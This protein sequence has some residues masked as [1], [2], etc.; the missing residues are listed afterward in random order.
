MLG[1]ERTKEVHVDSLRMRTEAIA[2]RGLLHDRVVL[3]DD[4][5]G[6]GGVLMEGDA[7]GLALLQSASDRTLAG[8]RHGRQDR[9]LGLAGGVDDDSAV[10]GNGLQRHA[11]VG[12]LVDGMQAH[13]CDGTI[14]GADLTQEVGSQRRLTL[15]GGFL[16]PRGTPL[17]PQVV[18]AAQR[19]LIQR[20]ER[21][22]CLVLAPR[23]TAPH[24]VS[25]GFLEGFPHAGLLDRQGAV[26]EARDRS[27][28]VVLGDGYECG[29]RHSVLVR[30]GKGRV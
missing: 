20:D 5:C 9:F 12:V 13:K 4:G 25:L 19:I 1:A 17:C 10:V 21:D 7:L 26:L 28:L 18:N 24:P 15:G 22:L 6:I 16:D 3:V 27:D 8:L 30:Q 2:L 23:V 11:Q 29:D 14:L